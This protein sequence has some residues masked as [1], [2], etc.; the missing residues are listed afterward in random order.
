MYGATT[1]AIEVT[2]EPRFLDDQ[3]DP[4]RPYYVWAYTIC[5][6]NQGA[7]TVQ[8]RERYWRITNAFGQVEEVR[9]E[10]VVGEQP[11]LKP[12]DKFIY[13]SG[14]PLT[15]PSGI[16]GGQYRMQT[17]DGDEFDVEIPAFSL[18]SP[19]DEKRIN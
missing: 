6:Q 4:E 8:L 5:I 3:S 11:T 18:D 14:A 9:G 10:G 7:E 17:E 15:T 12:G 19:H 2:V 16:M 13:T 1:R